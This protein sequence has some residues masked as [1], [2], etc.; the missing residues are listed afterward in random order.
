MTITEKSFKLLDFNIYDE[1]EEEDSSSGSENGTEYKQK[2]DRRRFIIQ[3]FGI[4]EKGETFCVFIKDYQPFFYIKVGDDWGIDRKVEFVNHIKSKVGKYFESSITESKIIERNKL[5]GFD[6]GKKHK[7]VLLK[8]KN[9]SIMNKVKNL[10]YVNGKKGRR[11]NDD[12]YVFQDTHTYLYE[13]NIPPLLRYFHIKEIS[14]SGWVCLPLKKANRVSNQITTCKYEFEIKNKDIIPLNN[15]ETRVPYKICSFDIEASSSHGDFPIPKKS[16]KKLARNILEYMENNN[17]ELTN[18]ELMKVV[19]TAFGYDNIPNVD[20]VFPKQKPNMTQLNTLLNRLLTKKIHDLFKENVSN[21]NTIE[22]AFE[23][24]HLDE[25]EDEDNTYGSKMSKVNLDTTI[26]DLINGDIKREDKIDQL[27]EAFQGAGFPQLEGDKTTFIGSTFLKYGDEKPYLNNCLTLDTCDNIKEVENSE[28]KSFKT[29]RELL[30]A[31]KDLILKEDPDIIIGYNIFGFDYQFI[32]IRAQ[33][34]N[35]EE[36]FLKLSRNKQEICGSKNDDTGHIDIEQSKIVIASGE[37]D[38]TFIKMNGRLQVD[39]Y[40]YFRR[41]YNLTS[42][43]LDYVSGYFIGDGVK[44][45]EHIDNK[46][47]IYS[48]NLTGLENGSYINFEETSHSSEYY[49]EGQKFKVSNIDKLTGT[50]EVNGIETPDMTKNV[51]WGLAKDDVTPQ[52][53]FR[54]TKEGPKE[55]AVIAKYCIQD[56]NLVHHLTESKID[57]ITG[58]M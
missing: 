30:L 26:I 45:I 41:D 43:K 12:G 55:R 48:K 8:F 18:S 1:L 58:Y 36:E 29:E 37:H 40:N 51:K 7:F 11:L 50:F 21:E 57:V 54:M 27:T 17:N 19:K 16:Y 44:K 33:E 53:I 56:C 42:Y 39:M 35:C 46:T 20:K 5:Y 3:I 52:D 47:K 25:E 49:K 24:M 10:Y 13:A 23:K 22:K 14:P 32:H 15:K 9:T 28:I 6:G 4:N 38:L 31:W 2:K 34:N